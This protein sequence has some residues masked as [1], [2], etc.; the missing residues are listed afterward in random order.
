MFLACLS[1]I[2]NNTI[3]WYPI[4]F[5]RTDYCIKVIKQI[6][7]VSISERTDF[8]L[9]ENAATSVAAQWLKGSLLS[10][11]V[12]V[13]AIIDEVRYIYHHPEY[14]RWGDSRDPN[15]AH[16]SGRYWSFSWLGHQLPTENHKEAILVGYLLYRLSWHRDELVRVEYLL[17]ASQRSDRVMMATKK[18]CVAMPV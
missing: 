11:T 1:T 2:S 3:I 8:C 9:G 10:Y 16:G 14:V 5:S 4:T 15:S 17:Y 12:C 18:I 13:F 7:A 6:C